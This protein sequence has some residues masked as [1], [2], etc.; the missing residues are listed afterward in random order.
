MLFQ[1]KL[2]EIDSTRELAQQTD[3]VMIPR[4]I[5]KHE[6]FKEFDGNAKILYILIKDI[7]GATRFLDENKK[8]YVEYSVDKAANDLGVHYRKASTYFKQLEEIGLIRRKLRGQGNPA[9]IYL[10]LFEIE[11]DEESQTCTNMQV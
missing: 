1:L 7:T 8:P 11:E 4:K 9:Q 3:F 10:R 6:V 2:R 5:L